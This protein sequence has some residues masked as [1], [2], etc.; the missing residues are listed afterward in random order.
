MRGMLDPMVASEQSNESPR[1]G[2]THVAD[3]GAAATTVIKDLLGVVPRW[4]DRTRSQA[5]FA[6]ML[7]AMLP[8]IGALGPSRQDQAGPGVPEHEHVDVL[9][10]LGEHP[11]DPPSEPVPASTEPAGDTRVA[12][13]TATRTAAGTDADAPAAAPTAAPPA[14]PSLSEAELPIQDYDSLAASQ[15]VPRLA[16]LTPDDLLSVQHYEAANRR[17]QTILNRVAQLLGG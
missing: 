16:T 8:C 2:D 9:S 10:V 15:V 5:E 17:R 3:E 12:A 14:G 7:A 11:E 6:R 13:D 4:V 1:A